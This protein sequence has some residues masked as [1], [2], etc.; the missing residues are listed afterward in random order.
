MRNIPHLGRPCLRAFALLGWAVLAIAFAGCQN[1]SATDL[2][3]SAREYEAKGDLQAAII[4]L[5]NAVQKQPD[6]AEARMLLG[7]ASLAAGDPASAEK[8]L[9]RALKNGASPEQID[10]WLAQAL[11]EMGEPDKVIT[12]FADARLADP[13]AEAEL[14]ARVGDAQLRA[15]K[16]GDAAASFAAALTADPT[17]LRAQLGLVRLAAVD[18]K[19]DEAQA[20]LAKAIAAHPPSA[21]AL[22]LQA[23]LQLAAGDRASARASLQQA[24]AA[25]PSAV[26]PRFELIG[27]QIFDRDFDAAAQQI[28]DARALRPSDLRL[29]YFEAMLAV[30][31]GDFAKARELAQQIL[32]SSPEHVPTLVLLGGV[33][34][35]DKHYATAE[36]MLQQVLSQAPQHNGARTLLARSYLA[37]G[38]PARAV[39]VIQPLL[40]RGARIDAPTLML[41][42]EA[43]FASGDIKQAAQYFEAASQSDAQKSLAQVRLGQIALASGDVEGGIRRLEA[44]T[45]ESGAPIQG[46]MALI[47]G[48]MRK[49]D[50][51]RALAVAQ[52]L[53]KK[54]PTNATAYQVLGTVLAARKDTKE[55]RAAYTKALELSPSLLPAAAGLARLD[56]AEQKPA[57]A[58]ARFEAVIAADPK[59]DL[60]YLALAD[61]MAATKAPPAEVVAL[62][63]RAVAAR[64]DSIAA[65]VALVNA[66]LQAKDAR[67]ALNTAQ[68]GVAAGSKEPRLLD[69]LGRAQ[70]AAGETNQAIETFSRLAALE[71]QSAVPLLRLAAVYVSRQETEKAIEVLL[72]AQRIAPAEAGIARDLVLAYLLKGQTEDALK[73]ARALQTAAPRNAAGFVL[74]GDVYMASKQW[75]PAERAYREALK[76]DPDG[77][78]LAIKL[79]GVLRAAG[80]PTEAEAW[81]RRWLASHPNDV[82][83]RTY[84]AE[85][86]LRARDLKAA[87]AQ[88]QALIAQQP[89]NIAALNNLAWA[90]GQMGDPKAISYAERALSLAPDSPLVLDTLGVLLTSRGDAAKGVEY[91]SRAV[92]LAPKRYDIRLNYAKALIKAGRGEEAAKE[93]EQLQSVSEDFDGKSEIAALLKQK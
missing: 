20:A 26:N 68:E 7:R 18:G 79:Y 25:E 12:E 75:V 40:K 6:N 62:L 73:Q 86:S 43:Y 52:G 29:T 71:P 32:K 44:A 47:A 84:V 57:E 17:N 81:S 19:M 28:K 33:E 77:A 9:R 58:R 82:A 90:L 36:S 49:G 15:R 27:L 46:D 22:A 78:A 64:P 3:R 56:L 42:G 85:Q 8:D 59:N 61:V 50:T 76:V 14:R 72:R 63:Q 24:I 48:Y 13:A 69:A 89:D 55:A 10:P 93:L 51:A 34:L 65:R 88:Y 54:D 38:Q 92:A 60:A 35:Q 31:R 2:I 83:F 53:V 74:E 66:Y 67:A 70:W 21:E 11:L 16:P 91:L 39:E 45:G 23:E 37:S 1:Q 41:A 87:V 4:Q 30:G 5:K 80:K